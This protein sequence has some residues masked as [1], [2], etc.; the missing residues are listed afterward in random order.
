MLFKYA[1]EIEKTRSISKAA[2]NLYMAQPNLSKAIKEVEDSLGFTIFERTSKGVV[3]TRKG[4]TFLA[5]S[6]KIL[7][8]LAGI[9]RLSDSEY[10]VTQSISMSIPR[11]SYIA[12]AFIKFAGE[13]N[14]DKEINA[15]LQETNS[16]QA[17][18]NIVDGRFNLGIIRYQAV[19]ENYFLDY[20]A[21]KNLCYDQIWE[22][23]YLALMSEKH[24]L[25]RSPEVKFEE[26]KSYIEVI[27]GD[28]S[29]PYLN[30]TDSRWQNDDTTPKKRIY[31]YERCNQFDILS[32]LPTAFM[33]VSPIPE[34]FIK[35]YDLVQRKCVFENNK[36][37]DLLI[38]PQGYTFTPLE[39]LL[40]DR[41]FESKNE[42]SLKK[43]N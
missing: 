1:I 36:H 15:N 6:R 24:A 12:A 43:Y 18:E 30:Q 20:L 14:F 23:E 39:K 7:E 3:P 19:Y 38:Y 29:V 37:K 13:L 25:A 16:I 27:H 8:E 22:F 42:V 2:E 21:D 4:L 31:L 26:L 33:W 32:S 10:P 35:R 41:I 9:S 17:I 11:G 40:I 34:R 5:Y 28:T